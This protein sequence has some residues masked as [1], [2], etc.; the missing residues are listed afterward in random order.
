M[1]A[2]EGDSKLL[3][4]ES[5]EEDLENEEEEE[6]Q[7]MAAS[8]SGS[9]SLNPTSSKRP[10]SRATSSRKSVKILMPDYNLIM[11]KVIC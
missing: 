1:K 4:V 10:K 8:S 5:E 3:E 9:K 11:S 2:L 7:G 6:D